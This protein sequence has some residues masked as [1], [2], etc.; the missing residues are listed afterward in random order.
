MIIQDIIMITIA[1][2]APIICIVIFVS[3]VVSFKS[4]QLKR[5]EEFREQIAK[6][7]KEFNQS[8]SDIYSQIK[9]LLRENRQLISKLSQNN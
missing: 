2:L 5:D 3:F 6:I 1:I 8:Q 9:E 7:K 4:G